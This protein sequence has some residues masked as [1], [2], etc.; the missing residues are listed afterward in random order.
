MPTNSSPAVV[1]SDFDGTITEEDVCLALLE[2]FAADGWR[3]LETDYGEGR[4]SMEAC[5]VGQAELITAPRRRLVEYA[6]RAARLREGFADFLA[7]CRARD[8]EFHIVSA[9][10]DFY[11]DAILAGHGLAHLP[12][13]RVTTA[14]VDGHLGVDLPL[15]GLG[16]PAEYANFKEAIVHEHQRRGRQVVFLGDGSTDFAAARRADLVFARDRL[17]EYCRRDGIACH[18]FA[19]FA[20]V[21]RGLERIL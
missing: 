16:L 3:Q 14:F 12:A 15:A 2:E 18:P 4:I 20:D 17:L 8:L 10:F 1:L 21:R 11:I 6:L 7:Y 9:G 5:L 13:T 19:T